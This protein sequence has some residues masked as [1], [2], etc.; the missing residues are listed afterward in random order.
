LKLKV[1]ICPKCKSDQIISV[2]CAEIGLWE[3]VKCRYRSA[4]FPVIELD[5]KKIKQGGK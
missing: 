4:I 1:K 3:C 2:A 5:T